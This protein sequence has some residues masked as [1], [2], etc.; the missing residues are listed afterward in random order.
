MNV[1]KLIEKL[2]KMP[3]DLEVFSICDHGQQPEKTMAP[4]I[5]YT[6]DLH[7][8]SDSWSSDEWDAM[9][10]GFNKEFVLL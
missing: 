7:N 4:S 8:V 2:Q 6:D 10:F 3:Q 1:K 5:A 9:E